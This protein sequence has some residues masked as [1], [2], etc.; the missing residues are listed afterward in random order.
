MVVDALIM[1]GFAGQA[2]Q[3][4][5]GNPGIPIGPD[6]PAY[7]IYTSGSTGNPKGVVIGH[8]SLSNL[9][10][11]H[12][13]CF[14][15]TPQDRGTLYAGVAFDAS[16]WELFPYLISGASLYII[17]EQ[18]RLDV[19]QLSAFYEHNGITV[20]FLPTPIGEQLLE[21]GNSSLRC[22]LLGG[23]KLMRVKERPYRIVNNYGPTEN[24]VVTT[25]GTVTADSHPIPIGRPISNVRVY[26][27][28]ERRSLVPTGVI[29]EIYIGGAG[30]AKCYVNNTA[31]TEESFI[32]DPYRAGERL[33]RSGDLGRWLPDGNIE[34]A[35]R[36]D[37]QIKI[38]GHRV[39]LGEIEHALL[40]HPSVSA[41]VVMTCKGPGDTI[42]LK[43]CIV[44]EDL[45]TLTGIKIL[46]QRSYPLFHDPQIYHPAAGI[47][48]D[49]QWQD[50]QE[51]PIRH[52][53]D[54]P[55]AGEGVTL[56]RQVR[57]RK[58]SSLGSGRK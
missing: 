9:C 11:W 49:P 31:M 43:A 8:R 25:S 18:V 13:G 55:V 5:K 58:N 19:E 40:A 6:D 29:G 50:R 52:G 22:L 44:A 10:F 30:L 28:N 32:P 12:V 33:Y 21:T 39:E 2:H 4:E 37:Q 36:R 51:H 35:G 46:S 42:E 1:E 15:V 41:A 20:A 26:I 3:F 56:P 24:T 53:G 23:D 27:L 14:S 16:V 47:P 7:I 45:L 57:Y 38:R 48:I 54:R 34:F 17:P